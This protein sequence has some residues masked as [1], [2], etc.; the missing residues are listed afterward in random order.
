MRKTIKALLRSSVICLFCV[1]MLTSSSYAWYTEFVDG[2]AEESAALL[3]SEA[4]PQ[5]L[6]E[7]QMFW[8]TQQ[9]ET[10]AGWN[11][12][13]SAGT[14]LETTTALFNYSNWEPGYAAVRY[15]DMELRNAANPMKYMVN[16]AIAQ[17]LSED[18]L[19]KVIDVYFIDDIGKREITS[20]DLN[21]SSY[22]GTL[23]AVSQ[24]NDLVW[25]TLKN[26]Q[27]VRAAI[28]LKMKEDA[29][30][31]YQL[32]EVNFDLL[33]KLTSASTNVTQ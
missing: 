29:G 28:V 13:Q 31:V 11:A 16:V 17:G 25:G 8:S 2:G 7:V 26:D 19:A 20:A 27:S 30:N 12:A 21:Q 22:K 9:S 24:N 33:F 23:A 3:T 32:K 15:V 5:T 6:P 10:T 18:H 14:G 4:V 1:S